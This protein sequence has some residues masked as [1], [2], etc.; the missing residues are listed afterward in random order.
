MILMMLIYSECT[1]ASAQIICTGS[2]DS[3]SGRVC[4]CGSAAKCGSTKPVF[5]SSLCAACKVN[6]S[7]GDGT[8]KGNCPKD[9]C[10]SDGSCKA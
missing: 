3:C 6:G 4:K 2:S 10:Q 7:A 1:T 8:A 9:K 5:E